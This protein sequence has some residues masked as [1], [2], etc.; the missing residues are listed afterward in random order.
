MSLEV[1]SMQSKRSFFNRTLFRK[2]LGRFWPLWGGVSLI[3]AM[4]PLYILLSLLSGHRRVVVDVFEFS[5]MLYGTAAM[6]VP[7]F[8][9][10]YAI[11]CAMVVWS[12]LYSARSVGLIHTLP[13]DRTCLFVTGT[14]SGLAMMLI[15]YVI[16]G[17]M[18]C[19]IAL[20]WGF[21]SLTAVVET[22]LAV[23]LMSL[24]FFG[25]ATLCAMVT[26]NL[27]A[28]PVFY[29][30]FNFLAPLTEAL[31]TELAQAFL[32]GLVQS[33]NGL[34][35]V[36]A[37]VIQIYENFSYEADYQ[38]K[39]VQ[40]NGFGT[41][42]A[43]GLV[44]VVMLACAWGLYRGRK[45]ES[46]GDVVS[47][48]WLR[49]VFRYGLAL[50]SGLTLGRLLYEVIWGT[51][52]QQSDYAD[53][54]PMTVCMAVTGVLG[55]YAASMLLEKSLRVFRGSWKGVIAVCAAAGAIC[56][57]VSSDV[58]GVESRV[59]RM[60]QVE[61]VKISGILVEDGITTLSARED[62]ELVEK[63]LSIHQAIVDDV[64]YIRS[65]TSDDYVEG[66]PYFWGD[67]YLT[68]TLSDG[69]QLCRRYDL[70]YT[71][72][73]SREAG[74]YDQQILALSNDPQLQ[75]KAVELP[76]GSRLDD[77]YFFDYGSAAQTDGT[78][79]DAQA[80]YDA[81]LEDARSG[82]IQSFSFEHHEAYGSGYESYPGDIYME[83]R[84]RNGA[85]YLYQSKTIR[86]RPTMTNTL[87]A[88][89]DMGCL[90]EEALS[91]WSASLE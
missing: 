66:T 72:D 41:V 58:F 65:F 4:A 84:V 52:F 45:S 90:T 36:L 6:F 28:L 67:L 53:V 49:P 19:L 18:I 10:G 40:L 62:P 83:Y 17:G 75:V 35:S 86:L 60:D 54:L 30:L 78:V 88:L 73:R 12:Y 34:S 74:T 85:A 14:A 21:F 20:G 16:V 15:P 80:L 23:I 77:I 11:L 29:L 69:S 46:A 22:A 5:E 27:F 8:T 24:Q 48:R 32:V 87:A 89:L 51:L 39:T 91:D 25:F 55:Y 9:M 1:S 68:Y 70:T 64:E 44:G 31:V 76:A 42:A 37:P 3:G 59:P 61:T 57:C 47:F 43:Y 33:G 82:N 7:A 26:G 79:E 38:L 63:V 2:N 71:A 50:F 81:L 13:V 56:L